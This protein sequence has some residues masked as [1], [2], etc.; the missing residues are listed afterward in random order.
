MKLDPAHPWNV[1]LVRACSTRIGDDRRPVAPIM[2]PKAGI[3]P[4][5]DLGSH[6]EVVE[7][8]WDTLG[9]RLREECRAV[10]YGAPGLV[11]PASGAVLALAY[12]TGYVIRIPNRRMEAAVQAG[13]TAE[14]R[15]SDGTY[16]NIAHLFG[17]GWMF[18]RWLPQEVDW[19]AEAIRDVRQD[20]R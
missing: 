8:L 4:Y 13:F 10:I 3:N 9:A 2:K 7:R 18:G 14:Q 11:D 5:W 6:P 17:Q 19:I 15:W 12:G 1:G 16:T 20:E